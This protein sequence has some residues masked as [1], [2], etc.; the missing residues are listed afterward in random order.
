[1]TVIEDHAVVNPFQVLVIVGVICFLAAVLG[2]IVVFVIRLKQNPRRIKGRVLLYL[3]G[4][5]VISILLIL[6]LDVKSLDYDQVISNYYN[7][8]NYI[9]HDSQ[10]DFAVALDYFRKAGGVRD[11]KATAKLMDAILYGEDPETARRQIGGYLSSQSTL[12][13]NGVAAL[14][15]YRISHSDSFEIAL[16]WFKSLRKELEGSEYSKELLWPD[17]NLS[18]W[19]RLTKSKNSGNKVIVYASHIDYHAGTPM[20]DIVSGEVDFGTMLE[21]PEEYLPDEADAI[22][23]IVVNIEYDNIRTGFYPGV[24]AAYKEEATVYLHFWQDALTTEEYG[25]VT[26]DDPPSTLYNV[27]VEGGDYVSKISDEADAAAELRTLIAK[28]VADIKGSH[29]QFER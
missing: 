29:T 6:L 20:D 13:E 28:A 14:I 15:C 25:T 22:G 2:L 8:K 26:A 7:G 12:T 16:A 17:E 10:R 9:K 18:L 1:M 19:D 23:S 21:I 5:A 24:G 3:G 4:V 27:N 11:A